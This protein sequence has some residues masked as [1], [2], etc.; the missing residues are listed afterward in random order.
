MSDSMLQADKI[1]KSYGNFRALDEFSFEIPLGK[2]GRVTGLLGPNGAGKT[3]FIH[4]LLGIQNF[5]SGLITLNIEGKN[6]Q[7]PDNLLKVKD[8]IGY[9]PEK[10]TRMFRTTAMKYVTLFGQLAGLPKKDSKARAFD[11]LHYVGL[12]EARYRNMEEFSSGMLQRVKLATALVQDPE[13]LILD[14]P[15]AGMDPPGR[16]KMLNLISDLGHN[17]GKYI[18]MSTHLLP[19]VEKTSDYVVVISQ[20]KQVMQGDL[21]SILE[22]KEGVMPTRIQVSGSTKKFSKI[23]A[24]NGIEITNVSTTDITCLINSEDD[25]VY[26]NIFKLAKSQNLNIRQLTSQRLSLE[27]VFF[28]VIESSEKI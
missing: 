21:K 13:I 23:L 22:R 20:G 19:D 6:Y 14:E 18:I 7:L 9:M 24:D 2:N 11:V 17:H 1:I 4:S 27:D 3:T 26:M 25:D 10:E 8:F 5:Q 28:D 12:E 15:T 16:E